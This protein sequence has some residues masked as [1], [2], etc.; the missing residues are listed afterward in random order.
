VE[1]TGGQLGFQ[2]ERSASNGAD[3]AGLP[4]AGGCDDEVRQGMA[5]ALVV[6]AAWIA[7]RSGARAR[8][9]LAGAAAI[10]RAIRRAWCAIACGVW[11]RRERRGGV[12][13]GGESWARG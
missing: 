9:E 10:M 7:C 12:Y 2:R 11:R 8:P 13:I 1:L 6:V 3:D 4:G 5:S